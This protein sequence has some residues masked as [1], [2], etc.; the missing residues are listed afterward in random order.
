MCT[1]HTPSVTGGKGARD[2]V[3]RYY[4]CISHHPLFHSG[5]SWLGADIEESVILGRFGMSKIRLSNEGEG[6][7]E[8]CLKILPFSRKEE[9]LVI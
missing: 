8:R 2:K 3:I 1:S 6:K 9:I 5:L 7:G 4:K